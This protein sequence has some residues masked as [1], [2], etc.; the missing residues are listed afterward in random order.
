MLRFRSLLAE[1]GIDFDQFQQH[2]R[3]RLIV[4]RLINREVSS[5]IQ[6][7]KAEV[8]QQ[9]IRQQGQ[10]QKPASLRFNQIV[11]PLPV[12]ASRDEQKSAQEQALKVRTQFGPTNDF[13]TVAASLPAAQNQGDSGW[14]SADQLPAAFLKNLQNTQVGDIIG[15]FRSGQGYHLLQ[16]TGYRSGTDQTKPNPQILARHI[17][18]RTDENIG[19]QA[20]RDRLNQL[21]Q[22]ITAGEDFASLARSY[23]AD[24]G[25]AIK[26][27]DLGWASP[28]VMVP[29]FAKK[30]QQT[31]INTISQPF[32]TQFGWHIVE[33]LGKRDHDD[34]DHQ[35]RQVA[36]KVIQAQKAEEAKIRYLQRLRAEAYVDIRSDDS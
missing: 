13:Q 3:N 5:Q 19:D 34:S 10:Q 12:N 23:S 24:P 14:L 17:L 30:L 4:S 15:P 11:Y 2:I 29:E 35:A 18:I 6:V 36:R 1:E 7:S 28:N 31:A 9:L 32:K 16:L 33:V 8:E 25:S 21:R 26:G 27:G 20:A 22:R